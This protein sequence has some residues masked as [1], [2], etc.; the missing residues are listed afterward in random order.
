V[1]GSPPAP[2]YASEL[3]KLVAFTPNDGDRFPWFGATQPGQL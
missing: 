1:H 3:G 2:R